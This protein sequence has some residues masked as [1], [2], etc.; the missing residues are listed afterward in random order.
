MQGIQS[1]AAGLLALLSSAAL[2]DELP[3]VKQVEANRRGCL[4][5]F[6]VLDDSAAG[7]Q[8]EYPAGPPWQTSGKYKLVV[9]VDASS[10]MCRVRPQTVE[11]SKAFEVP[12]LAIQVNAEGLAIAYARGAYHPWIGYTRIIDIKRLEPI[13]LS[14]LKATDLH[15]I[16]GDS[17]TYQAIGQLSLTGLTFYSRSIEVTGGLAGTTI[18]GGG[19]TQSGTGQNYVVSYLDFFG[20]AQQPPSIVIY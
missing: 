11:V 15:A 17:S 19:S 3:V 16:Y 5:K 13:N 20:E 9:E 8:S 1:V 12:E 18:W 4:Y 10:F 2:A 14:T 6:K 7:S